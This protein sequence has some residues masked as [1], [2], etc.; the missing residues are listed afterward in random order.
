MKITVT[1]TVVEEIEV[2]DVPDYTLTQKEIDA[3]G[4]K[5]AEWIVP[6]V[7]EDHGWEWD[8]APKPIEASIIPPEQYWMKCGK[9][10]VATNGHSLIV[11]GCPV[12]PNHNSNHRWRLPT[13]D[14]SQS[15]LKNVLGVD[16]NAFP[17]SRNFFDAQ[18][19][20]FKGLK[21][22]EVRAIKEDGLGYFLLD[23]KLIAII[24]PVHYPRGDGEYLT[25]N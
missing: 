18:Y 15:F 23:G 20:P 14:L 11:K 7:C 19:R 10:T 24:S 25:F 13:E 17:L 3:I 4:E 21:N 6:M 2:D 5:K 8:E 12:Y 16:F 1:Y 9:Y 22:L